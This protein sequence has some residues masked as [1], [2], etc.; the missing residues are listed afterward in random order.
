[1]FRGEESVFC[2]C[3]PSQVNHALIET[4]LSRLSEQQRLTLIS[5]EVQSWEER[6][7]DR[8]REDEN[9]Q[10]RLYEILKEPMNNLID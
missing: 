8:R 10:N 7:R 5:R 1:M 4:T 2:K 6:E 9:D 3:R